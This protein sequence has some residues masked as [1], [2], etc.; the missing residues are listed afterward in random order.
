MEAEAREAQMWGEIEGQTCRLWTGGQMAH[1]GRVLKEVQVLEETQGLK[2]AR[3]C[4][5]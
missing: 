1:L 4:G 3:G 5:G 2:A